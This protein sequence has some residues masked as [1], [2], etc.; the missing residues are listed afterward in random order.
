MRSQYREW[1]PQKTKDSWLFENRVCCGAIII[2][3]FMQHEGSYI[4]YRSTIRQSKVVE[5][6]YCVHAELHLHIL[7]KLHLS[8]RWLWFV[9]WYSHYFNG[10]YIR[11]PLTLTNWWV[12]CHYLLCS[13]TMQKP[14]LES[15]AMPSGCDMCTLT[16]PPTWLTL[17]G[18]M[19]RLNIQSSSVNQISQAAFG[20]RTQ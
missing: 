10:R 3:V 19:W 1:T 4:A 5:Y 6:H 2:A 9:T 13:Q 14:I 15:F 7:V 11:T 8:V 20:Q 18:H 12:Y 16:Q 17:E